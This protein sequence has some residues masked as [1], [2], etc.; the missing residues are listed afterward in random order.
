MNFK[1]A[2]LLTSSLFLVCFLSNAQSTTISPGNI[3]PQMTTAQRTGLLN[4]ENGMLVFDTQTNSYWYRRAGIWTEFNSSSGHWQINGANGNEIRNTNT[5]G[6]WSSNLSPVSSSAGNIPVAPADGD[7]TRLMWIPSRSAF[8]AGTVTNK[9]KAWDKDSIGVWSIAMGVNAKATGNLSTAIGDQVMASGFRSVA[10]GQSSSAT[11]EGAIALGLFNVASGQRSFAIGSN[12]TASGTNSTA[13]GVSAVAIGPSSLATGQSTFAFGNTSVTMGGL[14]TADGI[15]SSA[16]GYSSRA[17][18]DYS[19][20]F[21]YHT[22]ATGE[23]STAFG[24]NTLARA[25]GSFSI[26]RY[27]TDSNPI[28]NW[29]Q[30]TDKLFEVG[31]GLSV[32]ERSNALTLLRNGNMTI[33]GA[34]TQDSDRRLK[35]EINPLDGSLKKLNSIN[36][37][38][39]H[40]T[41]ENRDKA[42]QTGLIAQEVQQSF[43]EL[44]TGDEKEV[45][46]VNYIGLIPHLIE[47][48]KELKAEKELLLS[49]LETMSEKIEALANIQEVHSK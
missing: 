24:D 6:F 23:I 38:T 10:I 1:K 39:Y 4:A 15:Y 36:G 37:Y 42:L 49:R 26:G 17:W 16:M 48:V 28:S 7:G 34:L 44:V 2:L 11:K 27:N 32:L 35:T 21:G 33:A 25:V 47:A 19:S 12:S 46:S 8:R 43:P 13:L 29:A 31:N 30:D 3:L 41:G 45:L 40:W 22:N 14:T 18:A 20:V 9:S 5:G